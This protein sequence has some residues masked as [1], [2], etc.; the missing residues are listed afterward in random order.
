[1]NLFAVCLLVA[2]AIVLNCLSAFWLVR[3][4]TENQTRRRQQFNQPNQMRRR[5]RPSVRSLY[6]QAG[7]QHSV[8]ALYVLMAVLFGVGM[9]LGHLLR[10]HPLVTG[11]VSGIVAVSVPILY[12][13]LKGRKRQEAFLQ[14][15]P[16]ALELL[17]NGM[18]A[19]LGINSA[20]EVVAKEIPDPLGFEFSQMVS[21]MNLGGASVEQALNHLIERNPSNDL[22]L[23]AQAVLVNKQVGG[24]L[25]E[26]LDNLDR[27]IRER[28][29]LQRELHAATSE[30]RLSAT[31][32]A[33][34]PVFMAMVLTL[35]NRSYMMTLVNTIP[36][37]FVIAAAVILEMIGWFVL[38]QIL[39]TV[40]F[41]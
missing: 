40:D 4:V 37:R 35:L 34:L 21:G 13:R 33:L 6:Y 29:W 41:F 23:F 20:L 17:A 39:K 38:R 9:G 10:V 30:Q 19:G 3:L 5:G 8:I 31:V 1:M 18:R 27:T 25:A 26:V 11:I 15:L 12:L 32:L 28:F 2:L 16:A 22:R 14:Q 7:Y 24:N 36:G